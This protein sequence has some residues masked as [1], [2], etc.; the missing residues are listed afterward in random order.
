MEI[1]VYP[2]PTGEVYVCGEFAEKEVPDDPEHISGDPEFIG[3]LER[4][5]KKVSSHLGKEEAELKAEQACILPCTD[6]G[7]PVIGEIPGI[8]GCYVAT[9]HCCWGILNAPTTGAAMAELVI[10]G[11]SNIV[12][13][14]QFS[15]AI[16]V[17]L[18]KAQIRLL[19]S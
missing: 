2:R 10:H 3:M 18:G 12:D 11:H 14:K 19:R 6:D 17:K 1:V 7:L 16:F 5:A 9:G 13:L 15:P 8:K 4:V